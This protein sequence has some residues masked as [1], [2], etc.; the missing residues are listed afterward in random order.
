M[1]N[2]TI[3]TNMKRLL[4]I[5]AA[6]AALLSSADIQA[7]SLKDLLSKG[8]DLIGNETASDAV[9]AIAE[10]LLDKILPADICGSWQYSGPAV[11]FTSDNMLSSAASTLVSGQIEDKLDQYL[12]K[13]GIR[14]G[15]F[16]YTF[17]EDSTFTTTFLKQNLKGTYSVQ[18]EEDGSVIELKYGQNTKLNLLT[19]R[20]KIYVGTEKTQFLFN[21]DK[22]LDFLGKI[23]SSSDNSM[24]KSL[25][26]LAGSYDGL[27]LGFEVT[28]K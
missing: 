16:G 27:L 9:G 22:L 10:G 18:E 26:A 13:I 21:A 4:I 20:M 28:R 19:M 15:S 3:K 5:A 6:A 14:E 12:Q 2:K 7:Q 1:N 17:S 8:K 23:S 24:L 25:S 11:K